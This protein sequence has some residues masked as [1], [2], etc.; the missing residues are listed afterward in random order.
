[1]TRT[2]VKFPGAAAHIDMMWRKTN[3]KWGQRSS[4][5]SLTYLGNKMAVDGSDKSQSDLNRQLICGWKWKAYSGTGLFSDLWSLDSG[6][7]QTDLKSCDEFVFANA[8]QSAGTRRAPTPS[9]TAARCIQTYLKRNADDTMTRRLR[10]NTPAPT[11]KEPGG[12]S[13]TGP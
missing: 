4:G 7:P 12:R 10:P 5:K 3:I 8:A 1:M 6:R 2:V 13:S 11:W 9:D